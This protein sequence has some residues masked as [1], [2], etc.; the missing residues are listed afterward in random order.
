MGIRKST[1]SWYARGCV[2][3]A[4]IRLLGKIVPR[5]SKAFGQPW[6]PIDVCEWT[7]QGLLDKRDLKMVMKAS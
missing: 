6:S 2:A 5:K 7:R 3:V 4:T 1:I